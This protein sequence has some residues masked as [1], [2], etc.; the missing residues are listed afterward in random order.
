MKRMLFFVLALPALLSP[1]CFAPI[2]SV[3][4]DACM[5][6]KGQVELQGNASL[7]S[8]P[9]ASLEAEDISF[10]TNYNFG[11]MAGFGV[12]DKVNLRLRYEY[13]YWRWWN[14]DFLDIFGDSTSTVAGWHYAEA[15]AKFGLIP[16]RLAISTPVGVYLV[17]GK[18]LYVFDPRLIYTF[19]PN[20]NFSLSVAPKAHI[21]F[22][23]GGVFAMPGISLGFGLS[24]DLNKWAIRPEVGYDLYFY[25][26]A[27]FSY[28]LGQK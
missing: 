27:G 2:N 23:G 5:L 17:G 7:Y 15:S 3:Y 14:E 28:Y 21:F 20:D 11:G 4:E 1:A 10:I 18:Q 6:N 8:F 19:R 16:D 13:L 25:L 26:G 12:S 24:S 22:G 9:F